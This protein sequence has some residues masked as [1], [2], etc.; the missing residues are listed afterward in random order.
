MEEWKVI[1][2]HP[3]YEVSNTAKVRRKERKI[4]HTIVNCKELRQKIDKSGY[5][6][7]RLTV[8]GIRKWRFVHRLMALEFL[9]KPSDFDTIRNIS[10]HGYT[11]NH[12]NGIKTDNRLENL[13][14]LT[15]K[16]N[17]RHAW[18][19]GLAQESTPKDKRT[20]RYVKCEH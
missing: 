17:I 20:G 6:R 5:P 15:I 10:Y 4:K 19:T 9:E 18:E 16:D 1:T 12:I 3:N 14:W 7:I 11:V 13:E 8:N 2:G